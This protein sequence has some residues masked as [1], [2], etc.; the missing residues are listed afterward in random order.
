M[1]EVC[2][3]L[4]DDCDG[5]EDNGIDA[6]GESCSTGLAGACALGTYAC[7]ANTLRCVPNAEPDSVNETCNGVDDDCDGTVDEGFGLAGC[8]DEIAGCSFLGQQACDAQGTVICIPDE[9]SGC[10]EQC[11]G[12]DDDG[13]GV[14]DENVRV[15]ACLLYTSDAADD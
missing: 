12:E 1:A 2:N 13:D 3:G 7:E 15:D 11:N 4:D 14:L 8:E 6:V 9:S 10:G 5:T